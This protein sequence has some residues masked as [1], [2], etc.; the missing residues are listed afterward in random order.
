MSAY[1][2]ASVYGS[3]KQRPLTGTTIGRAKYI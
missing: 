3:R 1:N 2:S